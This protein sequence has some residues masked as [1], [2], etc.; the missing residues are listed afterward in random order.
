MRSTILFN[1]ARLSPL[2]YRC[3]TISERKILSFREETA[4]RSPP[5]RGPIVRGGDRRASAQVTLQGRVHYR[6][7]N[8]VLVRV[9]G[10]ER[11]RLKFKCWCRLLTHDHEDYE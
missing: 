5:F 1:S 8:K 11:R 9:K 3:A 4:S 10:V 6:T 7:K 2:G